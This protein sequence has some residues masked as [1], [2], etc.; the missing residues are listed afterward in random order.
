MPELLRLLWPLIAIELLLKVIAFVDL[1]KRTESTVR[2][3]NRV[4]W[5]VVILIISALGPVLYLTWGRQE[6][7][8]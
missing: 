6:E 1:S 3:G 7:D 5:A 4:L 8:G 2:G